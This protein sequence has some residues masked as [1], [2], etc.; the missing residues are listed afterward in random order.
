MRWILSFVSFGN[1][2]NILHYLTTVDITIGTGDNARHDNDP[3]HPRTPAEIYELNTMV[4]NR[5]ANIFTKKGIP[6]VPSIGR[7]TMVMNDSIC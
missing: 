4:A 6:V 1:S 3:T 5:M 2:R 7:Y